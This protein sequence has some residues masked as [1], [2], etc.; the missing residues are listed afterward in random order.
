MVKNSTVPARSHLQKI[1]L[2]DPKYLQTLVENRRIFNLQHCELNIFESYQQAYQVPLTFSDFVITSMI[3]GKKVMHL[4]NE[5]GFDYLPGE[6]VI[7]PAYE[8]MHIDFPEA[9]AE[10]PTQCIA[11][12]VDAQYV[13]ETVEYLKNYYNS[14]RDEHNNWQLRFTQYH[15]S[16][17]NEISDLIN[18][19]IRVCS[20]QDKSKNIFADLAL[21]ELLIRLI[22]CQHLQQV[23]TE[24][25]DH[26]N[27]TRLHYVLNYINEHLSER[28][29]VDVLCRKAYL[30][31][32]VF[33]KWFKEQ[34]GISPLE[35]IN[36]ARI[37]Q[38][39]E[40]LADIRNDIQSV[41]AQ[42]G[43][44]DVNYFIRVFRKLEG[45]TPGAYQTCVTGK[46]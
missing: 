35:Y 40:L 32:N 39:K 17:D 46:N 20:S 42:C 10:N 8:T 36:A 18:K 1:G 31:R 12:T 6:T 26:T 4:F 9:S 21:K 27:Q 45:I 28:I 14:S 29:A 43:F 16:N 23:E 25:E 11:L 19:I 13:N 44:S 3:R 41:S 2:T 30:S 34:F 37:R 38:A 24:K 7:V 5:P 33:F 15:F 22:Q